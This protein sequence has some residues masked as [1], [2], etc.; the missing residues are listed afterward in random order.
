MPDIRRLGRDP[1]V[2][3]ILAAQWLRVPPENYRSPSAAPGAAVAAQQTHR[4]I[5]GEMLKT[6]IFWLMFVM[7]SMMSTSGLMVVFNVGPFANEFGVANM[8]VLGM[9]ALPL[10]LTCRASPTV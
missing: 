7:M 1:G 2:I 9:A 6:P 4:A 3:G 5:A 10:S 8:L